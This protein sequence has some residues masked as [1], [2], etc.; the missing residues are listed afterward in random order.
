MAQAEIDQYRVVDPKARFT[1][2]AKDYALYRPRYPKE[3][4]SHLKRVCSLHYGSE[5]ADVGSGTG[6]FA[7]QLACAEPIVYAIEPNAEMRA[8]AEAN[9]GGLD[10]FES[11]NGTAEN[12]PL[13]D[14][15][16]DL[17]TAAQAFHWFDV[18]KCRTEFR[19]V[20]KPQGW[21]ALIWNV[22]DVGKTPFQTGFEDL[23]RRWVP[24]YKG[25]DHHITNE[26]GIRRFFEPDK[27]EQVTF[28]N[29]Q[30]LF[31]EELYGRVRSSSYFPAPDH[32]NHDKAV[33]ELAALFDANR[34]G[35][36]VDFD[37]SAVMFLGR[38]NP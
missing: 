29:P 35:G 6:I 26:A 5:V 9:Y 12:I 15:S 25:A 24:E 3:L 30:F 11:L 33:E 14:S 7:D 8:E 23:L 13:P 27:V 32:P 37:Y 1:D 2:R 18:E 16:V 4:V 17:V 10:G 31:W 22:R 38:V 36:R 34:Q 28:S 21:V 20:L 19:R